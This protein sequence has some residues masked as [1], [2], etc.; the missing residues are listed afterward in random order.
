MVTAREALGEMALCEVR[1]ELQRARKLHGPMRGPHEGY[2]VILEEVDALWDEVKA[3]EPDREKMKKE[4]V[5]IAAMAVRFLVDV[6][7]MSEG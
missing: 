7:E 5:Q 6:C 3:K 2:A 4:A 1:G